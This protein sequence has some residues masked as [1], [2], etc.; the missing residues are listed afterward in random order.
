MPKKYHHYSSNKPVTERDNILNQDFKGTKDY[1]WDY[2]TS[3]T[4]E[5]ALKAVR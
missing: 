4:A 1:R 3:M 5:L 2:D